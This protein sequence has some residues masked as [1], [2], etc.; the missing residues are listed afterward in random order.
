MEKRPEIDLGDKI[1]DELKQLQLGKEKLE[2]YREL[3]ARTAGVN[4]SD[5]LFFEQ[6][7]LFIDDYNSALNFLKLA[8]LCHPREVL[9]LAE[10]YY[11]RGEEKCKELE[12][13]I[14]ERARK[15]GL[16]NLSPEFWQQQLAEVEGFY[17]GDSMERGDKSLDSKQEEK[18]LTKDEQETAAEK[19]F[20]AWVVRSDELVGTEWENLNINWPP[21][22][23]ASKHP[24]SQEIP[25]ELIKLK[26]KVEE[27]EQMA[28][29][30][31]GLLSRKE[32]I[33]AQV[34]ELKSQES[35]FLPFTEE[36]ETEPIPESIDSDLEQE[37]GHREE[38]EGESIVVEEPEEKREKQDDPEEK[39][40]VVEKPQEKRANKGTIIWKFPVD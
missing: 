23:K 16:R 20:M 31:E 15:T 11:E 37:L 25:P 28:K 17:G 1:R 40:A 6:G 7:Q 32:E 29:A 18:L 38:S 33:L 9:L 36:R 12:E 8:E 34:K 24:D 26:R 14:K 5:K 4:P 3:A 13:A 19:E 22:S 21:I 35:D 27:T 2:H 30:I 10:A 39:P